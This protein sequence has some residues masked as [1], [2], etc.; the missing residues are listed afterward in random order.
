MQDLQALF[1]HDP[2]CIQTMSHWRHCTTSKSSHSLLSVTAAIASPNEN[3]PAIVAIVAAKNS[4]TLD[5]KNG[6]SSL[7]VPS[8]LSGKRARKTKSVKK[9][10]PAT[11]IPRWIR[12][13]ATGI[14]HF[15]AT[16]F[17]ISTMLWHSKP[18]SSVKAITCKTRLIRAGPYD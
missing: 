7:G 16:C 17:L 4:E 13:Y 2:I 15:W 3:N 9:H 10:N 8:A 6:N 14:I 11:A 1:S 12:L 5:R 18:L